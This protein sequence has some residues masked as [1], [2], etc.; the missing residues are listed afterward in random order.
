M[1]WLEHERDRIRRSR[2]YYK[3]KYNEARAALGEAIRAYNDLECTVNFRG[4][5]RNV[6]KYGAYS[7]ASRRAECDIGAG[8]SLRMATS[9]VDGGNLKDPGIV[10]RHE[11]LAAA[12]KRARPRI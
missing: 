9:G 8:A 10:V 3:T 6:S 5:G 12:A 1:S 11:H 4:E 7:I 2:D